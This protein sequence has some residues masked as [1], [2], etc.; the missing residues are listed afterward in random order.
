MD[1][2]DDMKAFIE[3]TREVL[4]ELEKKMKKKGAK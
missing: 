2:F 1:R 4:D 3:K